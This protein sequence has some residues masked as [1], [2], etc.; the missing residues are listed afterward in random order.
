MARVISMVFPSTT[1]TARAIAERDCTAVHHTPWCFGTFHLRAYL[2]TFGCPDSML[3]CFR[4]STLLAG[5][6]NLTAFFLFG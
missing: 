6:C 1:D 3:P 5:R 2:V 4:V